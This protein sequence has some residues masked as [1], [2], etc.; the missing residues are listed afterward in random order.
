MI[1]VLLVLL[2]CHLSEFD[3]VWS[4]VHISCPAALDDV[5]ELRVTVRR[6]FQ[7]AP[8]NIKRTCIDADSVQ[9]MV[10]KVTKNKYASVLLNRTG[11]RD[12][13]YDRVCVF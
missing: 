1:L 6:S 7:P 2:N 13:C 4:L 5:V 8:N 12:Y 10:A 9:S 3:E 11:G